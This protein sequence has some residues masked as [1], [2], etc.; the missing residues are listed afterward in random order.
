MRRVASSRG[1]ASTQLAIY[2][3]YRVGGGVGAV[4]GGLAF[5]IPV[6]VLI[7]ALSLLFLSSSP[8]LRIRSGRP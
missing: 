6:V 8:P 1:P 5:V 7:I 2:S 3:A 4:V